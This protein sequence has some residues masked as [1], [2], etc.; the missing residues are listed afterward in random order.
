MYA[1]NTTHKQI[2]ALYRA[3]LMLEETKSKATVSLYLSEVEAM[4]NYCNK[5]QL[6][7]C[8]IDPINI[9]EYLLTLQIT[10]RTQ[11]KKI[12]ALRSFYSYL[13]LEGWTTSDPTRLLKTPRIKPRE[14]DVLDIQQIEKLI[15]SQDNKIGNE[16]EWQQLFIVRDKAMFELMYSAGLRVSELI[17][18]NTNDIY[19]NEA[20]MRVLGK[21]GKE[22]LIPLGEIA[23]DQL[24]NYLTQCRPKLNI[25]ASKALFLNR[26]GTKLSR[27]AI[28]KCLQKMLAISGI[29]SKNH[30]LRHSFASHLLAGG[31]DL[32]VVQ[33]LMGHSDI[34]TT[35]IYTHIG[36]KQLDDIYKQYHPRGEKK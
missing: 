20:M 15:N 34:S 29:Y 28:W 11:A 33:E 14:P 4:L 2:I 25:T 32:R 1:G 19:V 22:R 30:T 17:G 6:D 21:G 7:Y 16:S 23:L 31:A 27:Q 10:G 35:Q 18:L 8:H 9:E 26:N 3:R 13:I 5:H 36:H 24:N 12:S